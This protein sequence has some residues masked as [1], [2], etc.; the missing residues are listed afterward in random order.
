MKE[1]W[2][3]IIGFLLVILIIALIGFYQDYTSK[4]EVYLQRD[5]V[6]TAKIDSINAV[7]SDLEADIRFNEYQRD[8]NRNE[9]KESKDRVSNNNK[10][11]KQREKEILQNPVDSNRVD[12]VRRHLQQRIK[13]RQNL[14]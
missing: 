5:S 12:N 11:Y 1:K 8:M 14:P 10:K 2:Y 7:I 6:L 3:W 9:V 13:S 4:H